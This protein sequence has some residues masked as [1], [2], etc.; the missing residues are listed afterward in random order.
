MRLVVILGHARAKLCDQ[1]IREEV[2]VVQ[3]DAVG[4][5]DARAFEVALSR[6]AREA[7]NRRL[8]NRRTLVTESSAKA[9]AFGEVGVDLS[10]HEIRVLMERQKSEIVV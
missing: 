4:A 6:A 3:T 10:V 8:E 5:L 9:V 1:R 7:E 2:V